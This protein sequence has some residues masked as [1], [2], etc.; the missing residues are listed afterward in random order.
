[1]NPFRLIRQCW[2]FWRLTS[3]PPPPKGWGI[4]MGVSI[5]KATIWEK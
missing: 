5:N 1:M 3:A 4:A 2:R